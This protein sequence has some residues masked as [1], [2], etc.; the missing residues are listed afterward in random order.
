[1]NVAVLGA[2]AKPSRYSY[3]A[4][5]MLRQKGHRVFPVHP[6]LREIQG[7]AVYPQLSAVPTPLDVVTVYLS[8]QNSSHLHQAIV[9]ARPRRVIFNPGAEHPALVAALQR[10]GIATLDACT[11]V[12]LTTG[13]F[14]LDSPP[15]EP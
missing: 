12:L 2:S 3:K 15:R 14:D 10:E 8:A 4:V 7:L 9:R 6:A 13:R 5:E 11:L 1:M